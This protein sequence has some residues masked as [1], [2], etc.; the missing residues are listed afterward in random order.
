MSIYFKLID[1][2]LPSELVQFIQEPP[3]D[4]TPTPHHEECMVAVA[5]MVV[6]LIGEIVLSI[7]KHQIKGLDANPGDRACQLRA[8]ILINLIRTPAVIEELK[9][10]ERTA[11]ALLKIVIQRN[12]LNGQLKACHDKT[13]LFF[14]K[15]ISSLKVSHEMLYILHCKLL[16]VTKVKHYVEA[17]GV[18]VTR[19]DFCSLSK[20]SKNIYL[21]DK[22]EKNYREQIICNS[23]SWLSKKTL[24]MIQ[25]ERKKRTLSPILARMIMEVRENKPL[26]PQTPKSFGFYKPKSFGCQFY[27]M[28]MVLTILREQEALIAIK[29]VVPKGKPQMLFF[30][31][32]S[33]GEEFRPV[34]IEETP[35]QTLIVV[36]EGVVQSQLSL[37]A[38]RDQVTSIGFSRLMLACLSQEDPFEHGS[39][40]SSVIDAEASAEIE[41]YRKLAKEIGPPIAMDHVFCNSLQEE[42]KTC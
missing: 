39:T 29:T 26:P 42:L 37:E 33:P 21:I 7:N 19:L 4:S 6:K 25:E 41:A 30:K 1:S 27:E 12:S 3:S 23:S 16:T 10:L 14:E 40:L 5:M 20:L 32:P 36:F 8:V 17:S 2:L 24:S 28:E 34:E 11:E 9:N 18:I 31:P 13:G 38:F 22:S 15:H 35:K